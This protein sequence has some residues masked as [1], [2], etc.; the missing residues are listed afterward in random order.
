[1]ALLVDGNLQRRWT[2]MSDERIGQQQ[3]ERVQEQLLFPARRNRIVF[4]KNGIRKIDGLPFLNDR[5]S[6]NLS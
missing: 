3:V 5:R 4:R 6:V 1:M 2:V